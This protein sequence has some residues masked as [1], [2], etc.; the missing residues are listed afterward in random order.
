MSHPPP[1]PAISR[2]RLPRWLWLAVA[3]VLVL[4][5]AGYCRAIGGMAGMLPS[6]E[7]R[8]RV[9][10]DMV[11]QRVEAV[12]KLVS[13]ETTIR[14]VVVYEN[15]WLNS[16]KRSLVVVTGK[17]LAGVDLKAGADV[18]IDHDAR[19]ITVTLPPAT[20]LGVEVQSLRTYDERAGLWNPFRPGDR[21]AIHAQ[22]RAQ[23]L[24]GAR[25]LGVVE[26]A[27][28]SAKAMLETLLATDGYTVT[29]HVRAPQTLPRQP[30]RT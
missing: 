29:V 21:D 28:R 5:V 7:G 9:S 13:S 6:R 11:V 4:A 18:R 24:R 3:G 12:A 10:H 15:T 8:T 17:V 27:N 14:D 20:V 2:S 25:E 26:H 23:M 19:R 16:T 30:E 1:P 22:V